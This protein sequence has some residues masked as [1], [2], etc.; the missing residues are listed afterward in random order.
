LIGWL[1]NA[2]QAEGIKPFTTDIFKGF[3][4]IFLLDMGIT[5]GRRLNTFLRNGW[6]PVFYAI[7]LP[8]INGCLTAWISHWVTHQIGDRFML[9]ILAA[10]ASYISVPA[11]M[12]IPW[13]WPLLSLS[14]LPLACHCITGWLHIRSR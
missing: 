8:L 9:S 3:L 5:S 10:S 7:L 11:A 1:A 13:R 4:A 12:K 2:K 14:M 6:S